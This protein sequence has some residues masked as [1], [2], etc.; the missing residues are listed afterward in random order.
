VVFAALG[1]RLSVERGAEPGLALEVAGP[2]AGALGGDPRENLVLRAAAA[3][4]A[5]AGREAPP[6]RFLLEKN[7]PVA[8]GLGGGSADAAACLRLLG[9]MFPGV[10]EPVG[11]ERIALSLGAD[12]PMCLRS[13]T[14]LVGGVGERLRAVEGM[15]RLPL[16][17]VHPG[18][19]VAT[20]AVFAALELPPPRPLPPLPTMGGPADLVGWLRSTSNDLAAPATSLVPAIG[21]SIAALEADERCLFARMSGS[22][23]TCFG[24]YGTDAEAAAAAEALRNARPGWWIA[25]TAAGP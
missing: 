9:R 17:L 25:A 11:V 14:Q 22:G 5:A 15:P 18:V 20:K 7:L 13:A 1:D 4:F 21:E 6:L 3:F 8:A 23:A 10:V 2:F 16:V 12:V 24:L 19:G